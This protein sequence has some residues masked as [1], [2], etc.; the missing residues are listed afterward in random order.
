MISA[1]HNPYPYNGIKIFGE[2]GYKLSDELEEQIE[3]IVL[4]NTPPCRPAAADQLGRYEDASFALHDYVL[5]LSHTTA[6]SLEGMRLVIDCANGSASTTAK[7]LFEGLGAECS[8]LSCTPDGININ[9]AC[10]STDMAAL[11]EES[12]E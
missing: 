12:R 4:D 1:S 7:E 2:S 6:I 3:S 5:Y 11:R 9:A 10:G 8:L